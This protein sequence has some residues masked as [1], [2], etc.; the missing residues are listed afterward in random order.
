ME[1]VSFK[2]R[3]SVSLAVLSFVLLVFTPTVFAQYFGRNK[4]QYEHFDFKVMHTDHFDIYYYPPEEEVTRDAARMA[5]RWYARH[6][7]EMNHQFDLKKP[8]IFY[9]DQ[10]DFQQTTAIMGMLSEGTGGVTEPL[11][12]RVVLPFTGWYR[13][14]DHVLGHELVHAFQFDIMGKGGSGLSNMQRLPLWMVEGMAEYYS[15]GSIDPHTAMWIRDAMLFNDLPTVKD[16]TTKARYF[17]YRYGQALY[18]FIDG[19]WGNDVI[20]RLFTAAAK[21]GPDAAI[22]SILG[23]SSDTLSL[24][25]HQSIKEAYQPLVEGRALPREA[26]KRVLAKDIHA[27]RMNLG[28]V[29]S[30]D[31]KYVAFLS[32]RDIFSIDL[33]LADA[34]TGKIIRRL[35]TSERNFHFDAL[36]F[37]NSSGSWSP[38]GREFATVVYAKGNNEIA[39]FD[40]RNGKLRRQ[41]G[42]PKI[43]AISCPAWS[44][45]GRYLAFSGMWGGISDLYLYDFQNDSLI[46]L[47]NDRYAQMQPAWSPD[48]RYLAFVTDQTP[49]TDFRRLTHGPLQVAILDLETGE[50]ELPHL[51]KRG[52]Q[53]NPQFSPDGRS[54]YFIS[55]QDGFSDIYRLDLSENRLYRVTKLATGVSGLTMYS[56]ALTVASQSGKLMFTVF[57]HGNYNGYSLEGEEARG[58]PSGELTDLTRYGGFLPPLLSDRERQID[59]DLQN[60]NLGLPLAADFKTSPYRPRFQLDYIGG[61]ASI[62]F[63]N[64]RYQNIYG[65]ALTMLFSDMLGQR[66]IAGSFQV[67][68]RIENLGGELLYENLAHRWNWGASVSHTP[69]NSSF[70]SVAT[71][72]VEVNGVIYPGTEVVTYTDNVYYEQANFLLNYPLN[73]MNRIEFSTGITHIWF[74]RKLETVVTVGDYVVSSKEEKLPASEPLDQFHG[75]VAFVGDNSYSGFTSPTRGTRY[76]F[77]IQ[78]NFGSLQYQSVILDYRHYTFWR[79]FTLALRFLHYGWY[80]KNAD[81]ERLSPLFLGSEWLI[82]GYQYDS[83]ST[84]E[85]ISKGSD[86]EQCP[87]F[88]R[89]VGSKVAVMNLEFRIPLFGNENFGLINFPYLPTEVSFFFDGG[90]AWTNSEKPVLKLARNSDQRIPVFSTGASV[91]VNFL[92]FMIVEGYVAH[93]F[94]RPKKDWVFGFQIAPGW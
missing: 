33:F 6:A 62:G 61:Q 63:T 30:P 90:T 10:P 40:A 79:P 50:I 92:G 88:N 64:S 81:S 2:C 85:C 13:E 26:G 56:P 69:F 76:R 7:R 43:G 65:G 74:Y 77:E 38:D 31:G 19:R 67:N 11:K 14:N 45:D 75:S 71:V 15:L 24:L 28:P 87:V 57:E 91:R 21:V 58:V 84:D 72:P 44:P 18:A 20:M 68:G 29:L 37:V 86:P 93:P 9:A 42:F 66:V 55:D 12:D 32:E 73:T 1:K 41:F 17:P 22:D 51:F 8:I 52:K 78:P 60:A 39:I 82:R 46:Q 70:Q 36:S 83:F 4:V 23:V 80:G 25:W 89:L 34:N 27:G 16:L 5:E 94:Q 54:L 35:S 59:A 3:F 48:G 53:I 49:G 47:T